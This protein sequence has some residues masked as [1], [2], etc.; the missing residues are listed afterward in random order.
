MVVFT[1]VV[2]VNEEGI[3]AAGATAVGWFSAPAWVARYRRQWSS[4]PTTPILF[5][6]GERKSNAVLFAGRR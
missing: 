5:C 6:V 2:E 1:A 3:G 4:R